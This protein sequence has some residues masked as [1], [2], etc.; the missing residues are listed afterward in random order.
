MLRTRAIK[1]RTL[2][3]PSETLPGPVSKRGHTGGWRASGRGHTV[4][5]EEGKWEGPYSEGGG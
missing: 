4:R 2:A 5:V 3:V 1:R